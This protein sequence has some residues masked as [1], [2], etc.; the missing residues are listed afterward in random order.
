MSRIHAT[1]L[2]IMLVACSAAA[3]TRAAADDLIKLKS[4]KELQGRILKETETTVEVELRF[5]ASKMQM[6]YNRADIES[7]KRDVPAPGSEPKPETRPKDGATPAPVTPPATPPST[8]PATPPTRLPA[9]PPAV[10]VTTIPPAPVP[11]E[12]ADRATSVVP[13]GHD[14]WEAFD[15]LGIWG[16]KVVMIRGR[17]PLLVPA[18]LRYTAVDGRKLVETVAAAR[19]LRVHW[20]ADNRHAV[21]YIAA[22]DAAVEAIARDLDSPDAAVRADAAWRA[23]WLHDIRAVPLLMKAAGLGGDE[24]G[25]EKDGE[26]I[27]LARRGLARLSWEAA[28]ALDARAW[29]LFMQDFDLGNEAHILA[30]GSIGAGFLRSGGDN[31]DPVANLL[32]ASQ[33]CSNDPQKAAVGL[34]AIERAGGVFAREHFRS[35]ITNRDRFGVSSETIQAFAHVAGRTAV[36]DLKSLLTATPTAKSGV[37][38]GLGYAGGEEARRMAEEALRDPDPAVRGVAVLAIGRIGGEGAAQAIA[39]CR[40]LTGESLNQAATRALVLVGDDEAAGVL[41]TML[42]VGA[43]G[44]MRS[45][46][47]AV[48]EA[49]GS[50]GSDR[51]LSTVAMVLKDPVAQSGLRGAGRALANFGS[52]DAMLLFGREATPV[53]VGSSLTLRTAET[54]LKTAASKDSMTSALQVLGSYGGPQA[55][56]LTALH[57]DNLDPDVR[58]A[59]VVAMS[60]FGGAEARKVLAGALR[61]REARVRLAAVQTLGEIGGDQTLEL[62]TQLLESEEAALR[63]AAVQAIGAAGGTRAFGLLVR[64]T[65][66]KDIAVR[67]RA[68]QELGSSGNAQAVPLLENALDAPEPD[69]RITAV[70]GLSG[71]RSYDIRGIFLKKLANEKSPQVIS[72]MTSSL[73][74]RYPNDRAVQEAIRAYPDPS[75]RP[76]TGQQPQPWNPMPMTPQPRSPAL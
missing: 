52:E 49:L 73:R 50:I 32:V 55:L 72:A 13:R 14:A 59:A 8:P 34:R 60:Q 67:T 38:A 30:L 71:I 25:A 22:P 58:R 51:A 39:R 11:P 61:D 62:L 5:G 31:T 3:G 54:A 24:A 70:R 17:R 53:D 36:K 18:K 44:R 6:V 19:G 68:L 76:H 4:G 26:V 57:A 28:V 63:T 1:Y 45:D 56:A 64:A 40:T 75:M 43:E 37:I 16:S 9:T 2:V 47:A 33:V 69:V 35:S 27:R 23:G 15:E 66:H 10:N 46:R 21:L 42:P 65:E 20:T 29:R 41:E 12:A 48:V 74:W 7:I